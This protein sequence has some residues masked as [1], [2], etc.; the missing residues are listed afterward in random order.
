[1]LRSQIRTTTQK[2]A[3]SAQ[4]RCAFSLHHSY[5]KRRHEN[6]SNEVLYDHTELICF[7]VLVERK[8]E[9]R[10]KN[11]NLAHTKDVLLVCIIHKSKHGMKTFRMKY[12]TTI[13]SLFDFLST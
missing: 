7:L 2:S 8:Y 9:L 5:V 3:P 6:L 11:A 1:M 12:Y 4:Y 13:L 10:R